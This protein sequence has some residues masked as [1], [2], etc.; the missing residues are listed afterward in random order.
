MKKVFES[1][2]TYTLVKKF[3]IYKVMASN[4]FINYSLFGMMMSYRL[5]GKSITN[6]II[7]RTCASIFTGGV[8]LSDLTSYI[9]YLEKY[10]IG[11]IG[12]YVVEG[13]RDAENSVLDTF[14]SF[15]M[16]AVEQVSEGKTESHFA[17]KLTAFISTNIMEK[18]SHAQEIF[19]K[20]I[21]EISYDPSDESVLSRDKLRANLVAKGITGFSE[22]DFEALYAGIC[23]SEGKATAIYRYAKGHLFTIQT[24]RSALQE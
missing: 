5:L 15:C 2:S 6:F 14:Y 17:L 10:K 13:V 24:K 18:L 23:N 12:C 4:L 22:E 3:F 20:E 8:T 11:T 9:T 7:E 16:E 21:L 1:D 19:A